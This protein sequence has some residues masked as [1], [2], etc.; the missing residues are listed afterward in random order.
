[1][2]GKVVVITGANSGIGFE[3][4]K[5]LA[6]RSKFFLSIIKFLLFTDKNAFFFVN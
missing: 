3:T 2:T 5:E 4:C 1:M 6:R